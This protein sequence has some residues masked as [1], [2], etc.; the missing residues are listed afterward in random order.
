MWKFPCLIKNLW[1]PFN[2]TISTVCCVSPPSYLIR[3]P[4][5]RLCIFDYLLL[6]QSGHGGPACC[7]WPLHI[8]TYRKFKSNSHHLWTLKVTKKTVK[9]H[10]QTHQAG[11]KWPVGPCK[12][13]LWKCAAKLCKSNFLRKLIFLCFGGP[14][15]TFL[16]P[17][18]LIWPQKTHF[19]GVILLK[20]FDLGH[21]F[22]D[23]QGK[24]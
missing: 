15:K 20:L 17:Q 23:I 3:E 24:K 10:S 16:R 7:C 9:S 22:G 1:G 19:L 8:H 12:W 21:S 4:N 2:D 5:F 11:S 6:Q 18:N 13:V 14:Y